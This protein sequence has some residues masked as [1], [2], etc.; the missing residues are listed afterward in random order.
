MQRGQGVRG[1]AARLG[2][3][4]VLKE[5][6]R[7]RVAENEGFMHERVKKQWALPA[8]GEE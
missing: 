7:S 1:D 4:C 5:T 3:E 6:C 2:A 8:C